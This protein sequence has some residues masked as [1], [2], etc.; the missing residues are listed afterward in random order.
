MSQGEPPSVEIS[1]RALIRELVRSELAAITVTSASPPSR[2]ISVAEYARDRSISVSTVRNAIRN[3][4][5]GAMR[6]GSAVRVRGDEEI[7]APMRPAGTPR[8]Q[9]AGQIADRILSKRPRGRLTSVR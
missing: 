7:G 2:Q 8:P 1:L 6:I 9:S 4:K 3:G 5:L